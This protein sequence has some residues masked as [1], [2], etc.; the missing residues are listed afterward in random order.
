M[1][2]L[3]FKGIIVSTVVVLFFTTLPIAALISVAALILTGTHLSSAEIFTLLLGL[4]TLRTTFCYNLSIAMHKVADA[5]VAIDRIQTFLNGEVSKFE[6]PEN[7]NAC[8]KPLTRQLNLDA[9]LAFPFDIY[10][11]KKKEVVRLTKYVI[12]HQFMTSNIT[13]TWSTDTRNNF[14]K[15]PSH[16]FTEQ[17]FISDTRKP[18][19]LISNASC[20]WNQDY[21]AKTLNSINLTVGCNDNM[22]AITGAVGSGKI[23]SANSHSW[24]TLSMRRTHIVLWK[25]SLRSSNTLG[26]F[27]DYKREHLVWSAIQ[28]GKVSKCCSGVW[29]DKGLGRLQQWR[30][31]ENW[32]A[33]SDPQ[34]RSK[35]TCGF[36]SC[37]VF[38]R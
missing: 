14:C 31:D 13:D 26:V 33:W 15:F 3:R 27:R 23:L 28:P 16:P 36:S 35:S 4:V 19:L 8:A 1:A 29:F 34:W 9:C 22:L 30:H 18:Y 24:R 10:N 17:L 11:S 32:T 37:S 7:H 2:L 21:G 5:K 6:E 38:R 25:S 20:S 12:R